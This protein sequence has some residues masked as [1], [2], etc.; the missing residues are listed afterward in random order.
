MTTP[1]IR[2]SLCL[3]GVAQGLGEYLEEQIGE[4][5][6]FILVT[7][8]GETTQY[9]ANGDR[10]DCIKVL[11]ELLDRMEAGRADIPAIYNPDLRGKL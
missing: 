5:V 11:R 3:Q 9:V 1:A 8:A 7:Q 6:P 4:P 10:A 2:M